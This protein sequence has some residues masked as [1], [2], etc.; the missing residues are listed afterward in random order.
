MKKK[1]EG[2]PTVITTREKKEK[3]L[4]HFLTHLLNSEIKKDIGRIFLFGSLVSDEVDEESDIDVLI[5]SFNRLDKV[6][7]VCADLSFQTAL[8]YGESVEPLVYCID[9]L[10]YLNSNFIYSVVTRGKE[11]HKMSEEEL[12]RKESQNYLDLAREYL[13]EA[14]NSIK[15][16][17]LRLGVDGA[18]NACELSIKGLLLLKLGEIPKTHGGIIQKFGE[19]YI[20]SGV[21]GKDVGREVNL[22]LDLRNR[23]RYDFHAQIAPEN[24]FRVVETAETLIQTL[25]NHL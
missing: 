16:N 18:Y 1:E 20:K 15:A 10:R 24:V 25:E 17:D 22:G 11:I 19:I 7:E 6:R 21:M 3:A 13:R 14:Q 4:Q 5:F 12:L 2:N 23:A 9:E 8:K